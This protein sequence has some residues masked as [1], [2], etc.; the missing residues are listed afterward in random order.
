MTRKKLTMT[1]MMNLD[2]AVDV[3]K[4][5]PNKTTSCH[6]DHHPMRDLLRHSKGW[7]HSHQNLLDLNSVAVQSY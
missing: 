3:M 1:L 5:Y 4:V 2:T 7:N 6:H